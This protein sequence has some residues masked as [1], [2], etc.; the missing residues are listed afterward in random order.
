MS[1]LKS[2]FMHSADDYQKLEE[3][4]ATSE[5]IHADLQKGSCAT[6]MNVDSIS[7]QK[8]ALEAEV[9]ALE[10]NVATFQ[11]NVISRDRSIGNPLTQNHSV[12]RRIIH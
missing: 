2:D 4:L 5:A 3:K 10:T 8:F 12:P 9:R 7:Q 11:K 1:A 6:R